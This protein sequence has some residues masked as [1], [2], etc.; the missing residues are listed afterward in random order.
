[1]RFIAVHNQGGYFNPIFDRENRTLYGVV[2]A[3]LGDSTTITGSYERSNHESNFQAY[4]MNP[5]IFSYN[6]SGKVV[7]LTNFD[8]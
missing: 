1:G 7:G 8:K 6:T 2:E 4:A 3:D 5:D